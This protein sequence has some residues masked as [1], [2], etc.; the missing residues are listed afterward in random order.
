MTTINIPRTRNVLK[1]FDFEALFIE[2]LGWDYA[3]DARVEVRV[4]GDT[5]C[6][7]AI[8]EKRGV[9]VLQLAS[10]G[11]VPIYATRRKIERKV[12]ELYHEHIIIYTDAEKTIQI[13]QWVCREP[14]HPLASR[15]HTYTP[16]Q[17]GDAL[18]QKLQ[19]IAFS[20]DEEEDLTL[21][22]VTGRVRAAFDVQR[23][24]KNFYD[25]FKE[26][27]DTFAKFMRG[28]PE[29][30]MQRWYVSVMLNRLMFIYFIQKKGFLDGD[31]GYLRSKLAQS[32]AQGKDGY[33]REFL[34][35]LFFE[36]FATPETRRSPEHRA[37]LGQVPYLNGGIFQPHKVEQRYGRAIQIADAAFTQLFDFFDGYQWHLDDRPLRDDREINP[38]VLGYIFEKYINQKQMG[39]YYT[40]EDITGYIS[41]NTILPFLLDRVRQRRPEAFT[42]EDS[43][44]ALLTAAP[45]RYIY[46]AVRKGCDLPLPDAIA[47]GVEDV[48]Q[49]E[50]WNT[51]TGDAY[52]L[53]TEIWR[54][55]VARRQRYTEV[56]AQLAAGEVTEVNDLITLNLDIQ[57]F[58][59]DVLE[60]TEDA[61]FLRAF[62]R[63]INEVSI[64]DPTCGSGAFLFAA[65]NILEPLYEAC[66]ERMA[67]FVRE[68]PPDAHSHTYK[69]FRETLARVDT[70]PNQRYFVLKSIVINNLYGVDI[71]PEAVEIAKLRLFLKLVAQ[72]DRMEAI[73]PLPDI[74]FNIR[75]GNTLVGF[76]TYD[77]VDRAVHQEGDQLK[78]MGLM[79]GEDPMVAIDQKAQDVD[80]LYQLFR[81]QQTDLGG[82]VRPEDKAELRRR[83]DALND[84][85][86]RYLAQE[87]GVDADLPM[88]LHT[89]RAS[90]Q[91]FHWF[92]EFYGVLKESG[93]DVIIG[94][95][96]Y[97]E[98]QKGKQEYEVFD[99]ETERC[100]N[101]YAY[102]VER[103][104]KLQNLFGRVGVIIP[105]ASVCTGRYLTL[106]EILRKSGDLIISSYNDR[107][108]KLF[109]GL[110]H[111]RLSIIL[112]NKKR[113]KTNIIFTTKYNKWQTIARPSLFPTLVYTQANDFLQ[114]DSIPKIH[115]DLEASI[116]QKLRS[117]NRTLGLYVIRDGKHKILYTRKVS[118]FLQ[119]LDFIPTIYEEDGTQREPSE[120]KELGF[121]SKKQRDLFLGLL[122]SNLFFWW[123][124]IYS[125][126]R[127]LNK[128]EIYSIPL[129]FERVADDLVDRIYELT[130]DLIRDLQ[131]NSKM[132]SMN[133][134]GSVGKL[135]IQCIYPK[136]SKPIIDEIDH[137]LARHYDFTNEE[138][139]FILN[140]DIKYRMGDELF[141]D[142]EENG[143]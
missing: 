12:A 140:Y 87:Y 88:A 52:A 69:D 96:P 50:A 34:C 1:T 118:G 44:W 108:G 5:F 93:F 81:R 135:E 11:A 117:Q 10:A 76:A 28:I 133:F 130:R 67:A 86:D 39:A 101:L 104:I 60:N 127:N 123:T 31:T 27:H 142:V 20:L 4:D 107:P 105:V 7:H 53:P 64:I 125:D 134:G 40:Q 116:L 77:E 59:Q 24:T 78:M 92:V 8:A 109:D 124:T 136:Y 111:I 126:C 21:I 65:L 18:I 16:Q 103:S 43:V 74:D 63:A 99:Y 72:V 47:A 51:P 68:L 73:E 55:T 91:P 114:E 80:R 113:E 122:N 37:L 112:S 57:Q 32:Q 85:L 29:T 115:I 19:A 22:D 23:A 9:A 3:A 33:Y 58:A 94:N 102:I 14:G 90:H 26:E 49:R 128:R 70:H 143:E 131:K 141:E 2:E 97:V 62:W 42:G 119:I 46:A 84:E 30:E 54:E 137:V 36:G 35:P 121:K 89:W 6:L 56:R 17:A 139:D 75:A 132:Q 48:A 138:L 13:W 25:R 129:A 83:L 66:L 38:D 71:M 120:L 82:E 61:A 79:E 15:E 45:D 95:P 41:E 98:Y 100:G 106:Q 110:E